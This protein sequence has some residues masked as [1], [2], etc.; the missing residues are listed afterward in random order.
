MI[1]SS[2]AASGRLACW[3]KTNDR[4]KTESIKN[5]ETRTA[6]LTTMI[7]SSAAASGRLK[8]EIA[9]HEADL[10][11]AQKSLDQ[12]TAIRTKQAKEFNSEEKDMLQ[13]IKALESAIVV[14]SKHHGNASPADNAVLGQIAEVVRAQMDK[15]KMMLLGIITPHQKRIMGF[16]QE[17]S[18]QPQAQFR[19]Y[20]PQ[21]NEIFGILRQMKETFQAN[22]SDSQKEEQA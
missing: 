16:M 3:C 10:S 8:T 19:A 4:E 15:H 18:R 1:E 17:G 21:S 22:L 6:D 7:E 14:L 12:L 2:A 11:K 13:S 20:R 5:A 9:N